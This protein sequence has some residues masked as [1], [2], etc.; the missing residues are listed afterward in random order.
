MRKTVVILGASGIVGQSAAEEFLART[1]YEVICVSRRKPDINS[2]RVF[3]HMSVDLRDEQECQRIFTDLPQVTHVVYAAVFEKPGLIQGWA[4]KD[5][6]QTNL[7]MLRNVLEP[8]TSVAKGLGHITLLQ[9][10]KAYGMHLHPMKIPARERDERDPHQNFYW[11]QEDYLREKAGEESFHYTILRPQ[12]I[13]GAPYGVAMGLAPVIGAYA[14]ICREE[15][16]PFSFPGGPSYVGEAVDARLVAQVIAWAA[17]APQAINQHFNVTNG[18]V[19]EW[20]NLWPALAEILG[21]DTGPDKAISMARYLPEKADVWERIVQKNGLRPTS[22][23][24]LIGEAHH[25]ADWCFAYGMAEPPT[26]AF[27]SSIKLRQAGFTDVFDTEETFKYWL[28]NLIK[29]GVL[30]AAL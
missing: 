23:N 21:V 13:I 26:P 17:E 9:G 19:F 7:Q 14:A 20:R 2:S 22:I 4:E 29:R 27:V 15:G 1:D 25:L 8:L 30:P 11:L 18:D 3:H 28:A 6:M 16:E 10:T 12:L 24:D 5:Q